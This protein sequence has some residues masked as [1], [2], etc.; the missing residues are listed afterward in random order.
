MFTSEDFPMDN[1]VPFHHVN[2]MLTKV[3]MSKKDQFPTSCLIVCLDQDINFGMAPLTTL[4]S[5][6]FISN[7]SSWTTIMLLFTPVSAIPDLLT[8][9]QQS[10]NSLLGATIKGDSTH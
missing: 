10:D 6:K 9:D 3:V 5:A 4:S 8:L 2:T 7:T 1:S